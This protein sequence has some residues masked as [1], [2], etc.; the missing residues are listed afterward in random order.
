M[1]PIRLS[2]YPAIRR[3]AQSVAEGVAIAFDAIRTSKLRSTLTILGVVIGVATVMAMASIVRG[4]RQEIVSTLEVTGPTTLRIV[5]FFSQTP[6]NP[7]ALP[8]EV[9]IRP[10][11]RP[12]EAEAI[13]RLPQIHYS[14]I[15]VQV[16]ERLEHQSVRSQLVS[17]FGADDRFMEIMGGG[18]RSGR[19]F[20]PAEAS[21]GAPVVVLERD[22]A[23]HLFGRGQPLGQTIRV[24][25]KPVRVVGIYQRPTNF[26]EPPGAPKIAAVLPFATA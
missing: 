3:S 5:R 10:V 19:L 20:T 22:A 8:R 21:A 17:V 7:D 14:A 13:G 18:L 26:F 24:G 4:M 16:F 25:G 11:L 9:R 2:A 15:W 6:L 23:E 1:T 12:E